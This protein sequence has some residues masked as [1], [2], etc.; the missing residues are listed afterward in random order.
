M[1]TRRHRLIGQKDNTGSK[2]SRCMMKPHWKP[3][4]NRLGFGTEHPQR[5]IDP[6]GRR[7]QAW[8]QHHITAINGCFRHA[9]AG[10][11][12]RAAV[13]G[14]AVFAWP[15]LRVDRTYA[16]G[17]TGGTDRHGIIDRHLA[18]KHRSGDD[19]A[20]T[21]DREGAVHRHAEPARRLPLTQPPG[22]SDDFV[23]QRRYAL[24]RYG[25]NRDHGRI[26]EHGAGKFIA[27]RRFN[28]RQP[29]LLHQICLG[30]G[31]DAAFH[32][33]EI[34]DGEMF[35]RLR[36]HP[37]IGGN[38][39]KHEIDA[40]GA[41][42]HGV[43]EFLVSRHIDETDDA[44]IARR[45]IGEAEINRDAAGFFLLQPVRIDAGQRPDQGGLAVID[46]PGGT[47]DHGLSTSSAGG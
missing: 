36:H 24:T 15:V 2:L 32:P 35:A 13:T 34:D 17:K 18:G 19:R 4:P 39:Q 41:G 12:E 38:H 25:R 6:V 14:V 27:D 22:G 29:V 10:K 23:P 31:D 8:V 30:D 21:L 43:D 3:V 46:M 26:M 45:H 37:V 7:V 33:K 47:D 9:G 16:R 42:K 1:G 20:G 5:R 44:R 28:G 40:A 11:I